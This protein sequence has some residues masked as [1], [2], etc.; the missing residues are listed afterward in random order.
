MVSHLIGLVG[1]VLV[2]VQLLNAARKLSERHVGVASEGNARYSSL[3]RTKTN[4]PRETPK[5]MCL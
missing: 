1:Q 4:L 5:C 2:R 3:Y